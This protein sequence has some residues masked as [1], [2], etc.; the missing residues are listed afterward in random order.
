MLQENSCDNVTFET[1]WFFCEGNSLGS[2][3]NEFW[4]SPLTDFQEGDA[5]WVV[6]IIVCFDYVPK[7]LFNDHLDILGQITGVNSFCF[8]NMSVCVCFFGVSKKAVFRKRGRKKNIK[9]KELWE[10]YIYRSM[11]DLFWLTLYDKSGCQSPSWGDPMTMTH[12]PTTHSQ[13]DCWATKDASLS[14][15]Q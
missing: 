10:F 13:E 3:S 4:K 11:K 9:P 5:Q 8:L 15:F 12:Q 14:H 6:S 7:A 2:T 1:R